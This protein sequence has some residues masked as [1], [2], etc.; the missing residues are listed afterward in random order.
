[1]KNA[2]PMPEAFRAVVDSATDYGRAEVVACA[3]H[4]EEQGLVVD[5]NALER[6]ARALTPDAAEFDRNLE[7]IRKATK[8]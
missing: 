1:M 8:G 2:P 5:A 3:R 4:L 7:E 6:F